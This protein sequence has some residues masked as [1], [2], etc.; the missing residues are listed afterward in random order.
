MVIS[1]L[2][3]LLSLHR[4]F[5]QKDKVQKISCF[6]LN[7]FLLLLNST[8]VRWIDF[9]RGF[10]GSRTYEFKSPVLVIGLFAVFKIKNLTL[11]KSIDSMIKS[12]NSVTNFKMG[13]IIWPIPIQLILHH[14][15][16]DRTIASNSHIVV[17]DQ[18]SPKGLQKLGKLQINNGGE[19]TIYDCWFVVVSN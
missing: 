9:F 2:S 10:R 18:G 17:A 16:K 4:F 8:G 6:V 19:N 13:T 3:T 1:P 15:C 14:I 7:I 5:N 11:I 12:L